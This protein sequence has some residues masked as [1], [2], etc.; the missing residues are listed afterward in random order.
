MNFYGVVDTRKLHPAGPPEAPT[1]LA[2]LFVI[3]AAEVHVEP[4]E[5]EPYDVYYRSV[6][7]LNAL[8]SR[9]IPGT[10]SAVP[11]I[12]RAPGSVKSCWY[13]DGE[14]GRVRPV[15]ITEVAHPFRSLFDAAEHSLF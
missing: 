15:E 3:P 5:V 10:A 6:G 7:L 1:H 4:S 14:Q 13:V 11:E 2:P 9:R 12:S 8:T